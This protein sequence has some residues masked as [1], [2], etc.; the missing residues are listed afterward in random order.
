MTAL[1]ELQPV[2]DTLH[3]VAGLLM[4][5]SSMADTQF[6]DIARQI[7]RKYPEIC[8]SRKDGDVS[9]PASQVRYFG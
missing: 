4:F 9:A 7:K 5:Q 1:D 2:P 3:E 8:F 6:W